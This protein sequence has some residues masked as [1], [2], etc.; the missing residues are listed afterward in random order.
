MC[1][2]ALP[3]NFQ[4]LLGSELAVVRCGGGVDQ[5]ELGG[6]LDAAAAFGVEAGVEDVGADVLVV[7]ADQGEMGFAAIEG[8]QPLAVGM[9][10][11]EL[12]LVSMSAISSNDLRYTERVLALV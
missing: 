8:F 10:V 1:G 7:V 2:C 4:T 11:G 6:D 9:A 5:G 12:K 3:L